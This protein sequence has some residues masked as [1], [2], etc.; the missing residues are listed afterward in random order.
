[1]TLTLVCTRRLGSSTTPA[2]V[3]NIPWRRPLQ[4]TQRTTRNEIYVDVLETITGSFS[5]GAHPKALSNLQLQGAIEC[6]S[7]LSG[8]PD[9]SLKLSNPSS[10]VGLSLHPCVRVKR[11]KKEGLF[12]FIPPDGQFTLA[13]FDVQGV[14][15][16]EKQVPVWIHCSKEERSGKEPSTFRIEI[17]ASTSV[18]GLSVSFETRVDGCTVETNVT[19]GSRSGVMTGED[20]NAVKGSVHNDTKSGLVRWTIDKF[21][22]T[23]KPLILS[24]TI[25]R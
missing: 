3:S 16:L 8:T 5:R 9:L 4:A 25:K 10:M 12:S 23:Q 17:G 6:N 19:G 2:H 22:S 20:I 24:G 21:E 13:E 18:E 14:M 15:S 11:W 1:M 7:K